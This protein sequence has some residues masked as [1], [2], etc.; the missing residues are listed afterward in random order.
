VILGTGFEILGTRIGSLNRLKKPV[1]IKLARYLVITK[2]IRLQ[3]AACLW[4]SHDVIY[5]CVQWL[6][7]CECSNADVSKKCLHLGI[8]PLRFYCGHI[9]PHRQT[10][11]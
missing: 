1:L 6:D 7:G 4:R 3:C 10:F 2:K 9:H 8:R 11:M 5:S